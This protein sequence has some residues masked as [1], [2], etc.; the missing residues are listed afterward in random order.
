[1][2]VQDVMTVVKKTD[3]KK[4]T[5]GAV[6]HEKWSFGK[7]FCWKYNRKAVHVQAHNESLCWHT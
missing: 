4:E 6:A 7:E 2:H 5:Y 3:K 1:M